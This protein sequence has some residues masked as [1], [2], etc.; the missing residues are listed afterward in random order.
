MIRTLCLLFF[1][2][3]VFA[4]NC[5]DHAFNGLSFSTCQV[6]KNQDQ[7]ALF[8]YDDNDQPYGQFVNLVDDLSS[9]GTKVIF[10]M[11]AGMF[12][13][14][15]RP[16]GHYVEHY[17]EEMRV[18]SN[19]GPGNFGML[20]NGIFCITDTKYHVF[21]TRDY[22]AQKPNCAYATQS[23]PLLLHDNVFHP[24]LLKGSTSKY[25]R[26]GV[27]VSADGQTAYFVISNQRVNFYQFTT[28]FQDVLDVQN[29]LYF[30]GNVSKL[31]APELGRSG[32]GW[33]VGPMVAAITAT[34]Q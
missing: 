2:T 31:Y 19:A 11:N 24:R 23:G 5:A 25:I 22:I 1:A 6:N 16:V 13:S 14:D 3:P 28:F 29:A 7:I 32:V 26:N 30:D 12:H 21:E 34:D 4:V 9:K 10:A 8:L 27:G 17:Q 15:L 18:V 20:P 33:S